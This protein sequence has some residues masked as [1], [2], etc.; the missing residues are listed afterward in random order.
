MSKIDWLSFLAQASEKH[1]TASERNFVGHA[2]LKHPQRAAV[3]MSAYGG[4]P[5]TER[6]G[7]SIALLVA[8]R[9][10][11]EGGDAS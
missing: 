11:S 9:L 10:M 6:E 7:A 4:R 5:L 8:R 2:F 3:L 1:L